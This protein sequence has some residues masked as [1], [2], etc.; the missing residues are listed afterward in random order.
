MTFERE[1]WVLTGLNM[2]DIEIKEQLDIF[3]LILRLC[4]LYVCLSMYRYCAEKN[5][6]QVQASDWTDA[7]FFLNAGASISHNEF[8]LKVMSSYYYE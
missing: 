8:A 3:M 4:R 1:G 6:W 5:P 2:A 7:V